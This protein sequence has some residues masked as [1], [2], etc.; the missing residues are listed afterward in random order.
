MPLP[1]RPL[2]TH[3]ATGPSAFDQLRGTAAEFAGSGWRRESRRSLIRS[4]DWNR[5]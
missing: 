4:V 5:T 3:L 1:L 2:S